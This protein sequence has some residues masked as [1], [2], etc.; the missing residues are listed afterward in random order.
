MILP[1]LDLLDGDVVRLYQGDYRQKKIYTTNALQR[2]NQYV[3]EGAQWV[4]L[5]DLNGAKDP[6]QKQQD[7]VRELVENCNGQVQ[8]GGG[9]RTE[10]DVAFWLAL[11]VG[12]VIIGSTA[13]RS[14]GV[15]AKWIEKYGSER[16]V[17]A[18]DT[19]ADDDEV[20]VLPT[21]G[22]CERSN[23]TLADSLDFYTRVGATHILCTDINRDGTM[24]GANNN[25]YRWMCQTYSELKVQASGGI[26]TL[27]DITEVQKT[28]VD[29]VI[30]GKSL[31][32][33]Q[34]TVKEAITCWQ[35]ASSP[36]SM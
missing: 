31:L 35:N 22:W 28:G 29:A 17:L 15:V 6:T 24:T 18:L 13:I 34:F 32:E 19:Y 27:T 23:Q 33:S 25:L 12:R 26:A 2:M 30:L 21:D 4:H 36:A 7:I 3:A 1:A 10:D 16:I 5:V 14:P 11:G 20:F 9:V 8:L